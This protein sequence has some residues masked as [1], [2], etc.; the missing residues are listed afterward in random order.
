MTTPP[1]TTQ[2]SAIIR[3]AE[4]ARACKSKL[5][6]LRALESCEPGRDLA[7]IAHLSPAPRWAYLYA[8]YVIKRSMAGSRAG[9]HTQSS[10]GMFVCDACSQ[11]ARKGVL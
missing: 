2:L 6:K 3:E 5:D 1:L 4:R 10:L 11:I 9:D 7:S 8:R